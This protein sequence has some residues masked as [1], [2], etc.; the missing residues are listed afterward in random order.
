[1]KSLEQ[2]QCAALRQQGRPGGRLGLTVGDHQRLPDDFTTFAGSFGE[3]SSLFR[4]GLQRTIYSL[5]RKAII[6]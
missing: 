1:M 2:P 5:A 6:M 4:Y 3:I